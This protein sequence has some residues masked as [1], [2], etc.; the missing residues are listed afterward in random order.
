MASLITYCSTENDLSLFEDTARE[1][2]AYL[3]EDE[4][5]L[6]FFNSLPDFTDS[7]SGGLLWDMMCYDISPEEAS[8][9]LVEQRARDN[10]PKLMIIADPD[11]S[12]LRYIRPGILAT[13]LILRPIEKKVLSA[14]FRELYN[15]AIS[16]RLLQNGSEEAV[17]SFK[18]SEGMVRVKYA[19]ILFYESRNKKLYAITQ[20][21]E[22]SFYETLDNLTQ[23][24]PEQFVRCHKSFI[25][26]KRYIVSL[27]LSRGEIE[28]EDGIILP[29][30]RSYKQLIKEAAL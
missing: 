14:R 9:V 29:L 26:N 12:P 5:T 25:V 27:S 17:F 15:A 21:T 6:Q 28:L 16:E 2:A 3:D 11:I 30:S 23:T 19:D 1:I 10:S 4:W 7:A 13:T 18:S 22:Y 8:D 24:L 20:K